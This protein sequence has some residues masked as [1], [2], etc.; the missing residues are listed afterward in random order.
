MDNVIFIYKNSRYQHQK[1]VKTV[2]FNV[3]GDYFV[4]GGGDNLVLVWKTNFDDYIDGKFV[5]FIIKKK[6]T[7]Y[8]KY[9]NNIK[10]Q[11]FKHYLNP[12]KNIRI[13]KNKKKMNQLLSINNF[14][15]KIKIIKKIFNKRSLMYFI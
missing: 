8:H 14:H 6:Y 15:F 7:A 13:L 11:T 1:N 3:A 4:S 10:N 12:I 5:N 9:K 2:S